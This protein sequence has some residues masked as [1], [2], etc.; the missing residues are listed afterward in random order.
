MY[1]IIGADQKE[2]GP[3]SA[4]QLRQW[5]GE[6]RIN[7]ATMAQAEGD[8]TWKPVGSIPEFASHFPSTP[9]APPLMSAPSH[10]GDERPAALS[11]VSAPAICL[12]IAGSLTVAFSILG[13][14]LGLMGFDDMN[15][16]A[17]RPRQMPGMMQMN[18]RSNTVAFRVGAATARVLGLLTGAMTMFGGINM[19]K[20]ESRGSCIAGSITAVLPCSICCIFSL[21]IGVWALIVL[22]DSMVK[23][24]FG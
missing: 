5:I 16:R 12:M 13:I 9:A 18:G 11:K 19:K 7:A 23:R 14:I 3:I 17:F 20:L 8:A 10:G 21:P 2:Y 1:K 6:G 22:N 15:R 24:Q 4:D